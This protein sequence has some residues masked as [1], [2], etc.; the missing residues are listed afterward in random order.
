MEEPDRTHHTGTL[1]DERICDGPVQSPGAGR[2]TPAGLRRPAPAERG[3]ENRRRGHRRR[4]SQRDGSERDSPERG[5]VREGADGLLRILAE[6]ARHGGV[7]RFRRLLQ[8]GRRGRVRSRRGVVSHTGARL[9]RHHQVRGSQAVLP[10]DR[11]YAPGAPVRRRGGR[12]GR[13]GR[14]LR[15]A[16][17]PDL[18]PASGRIDR[19]EGAEGLVRGTHGGVQ[20]SLEDDRDDE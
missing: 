3:G 14:D 18:S 10:P 2:K 12:A 15:R 17:R 11:A 19:S 20:D 4:H 8:D 1:R 13:A 9:G 16:R 5:T 6:A 7:V